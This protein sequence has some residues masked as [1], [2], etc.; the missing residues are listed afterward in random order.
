MSCSFFNL[1]REPEAEI[2]HEVKYNFRPV[3]RAEFNPRAEKAPC[4]APSKRAIFM[5]QFL[6]AR[7]DEQNW[8]IFVWQLDLLKNWRVSFYVA[9][10]NCHI[11]KTV[12]VDEITHKIGNFFH[13]IHKSQSPIY[14]FQI[15]IVR[16]DGAFTGK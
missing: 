10:K 14:C 12:H 11:Q 3:N 9:N 1:P 8:P 7:V 4:K 5:W 6:F 2:V 13:V 16:V 15:K